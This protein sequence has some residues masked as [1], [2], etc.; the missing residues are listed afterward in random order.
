MTSTP[1]QRTW[2]FYA[3]IALLDFVFLFVLDMFIEGEYTHWI[4]IHDLIAAVVFVVIIWLVDWKT[5]KKKK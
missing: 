2:K 1:K 4:L 3:L 5:I